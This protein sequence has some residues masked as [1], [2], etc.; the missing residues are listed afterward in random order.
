MSLSLIATGLGIGSSLL[1]SIFGNRAA[2][3]AQLQQEKD[4]AIAN[5]LQLANSLTTAYNNN[6]S[7]INNRISFADGGVLKT[8]TNNIKNNIANIAAPLADIASTLIS[9]AGVNNRYVSDIPDF[10]PIVN[11]KDVTNNGG[12][13]NDIDTKLSYLKRLGLLGKYPQNHL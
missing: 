6:N 5:R 1:G 13:D 2:R 9:N 3:K 4:S 12:I 7:D 11:N 8:N 10:N